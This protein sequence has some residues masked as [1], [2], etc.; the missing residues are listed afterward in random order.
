MIKCK[1]CKKIAVVRNNNIPFC[2][3]CYRRDVNKKR[4][5]SWTR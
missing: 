3:D 1:K 5:K 2:V 4:V